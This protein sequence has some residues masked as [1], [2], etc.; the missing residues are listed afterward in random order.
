MLFFDPLYLII[1]G[2]A[3]LLAAWAQ[4]KI[5]TAFGTYARHGC[6]SGYTGAQ[7]AAVMLQQNGLNDVTIEPTKG[8][9]SDHYNPATRSLHLSPQVFSGTSLA[10]VGVACHE[11]GHALQHAHGYTPLGIR[12]LLVPTAKIGSMLAWPMI[13]IGMIFSLKQ[14]ALVGFLTFVALVIFQ[15]ITVP[16]EL[17][18]SSR[19][20]KALASLG[21]V[22]GQQEEAGVATVLS[23]AAWTY[24][25]ATI[26]ALAQLL[27]FALQL[28]L[29]GGGD[30]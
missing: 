20:K 3:M 12:T 23:A 24:V 26:T 7:A 8:F 17:D 19:A 10:A 13:F 2:P 25:A 21:I 1:V 15:I 30:D 27:Y 9:L 22:R 28:G 14:L 5:K 6:Y 29:L 11:A 16:V 18:A 4:L